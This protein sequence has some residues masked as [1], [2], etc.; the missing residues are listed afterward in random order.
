MEYTDKQFVEILR[1]LATHLSAYWMVRRGEY[2]RPKKLKKALM[3]DFHMPESSV[4]AC[5]KDLMRE[6]SIGL[7]Q[8][9]KGEDALYVDDNRVDD[10]F[11]NI[12]ILL[13]RDHE[14]NVRIKE[15]EKELEESKDKCKRIKRGLDR[16]IDVYGEEIWLG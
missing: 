6:D 15:L 10:F 2:M 5:I 16:Y 9:Y 13:S 14:E 12:D 8:Y 1:H 4:R 11:E 7:I 3:E